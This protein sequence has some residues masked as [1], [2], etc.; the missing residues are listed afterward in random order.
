MK[1]ISSLLFSL[2]IHSLLAAAVITLY[3]FA[4]HKLKSNKKENEKLLCI[5]LK[6]YQPSQMEA[7]RKSK[8]SEKIYKR[9]NTKQKKKQQVE[10]KRKIQK[11]KTKPKKPKIAVKKVKQE[12]KPTEKKRVKTEKK[13][14]DTKTTDQTPNDC[15]KMQKQQKSKQLKETIAPS[16]PHPKPIKKQNLSQQYIAENI[17]S[18]RELIAENLYYPRKARRRGLEGVVKVRFTLT[19]FGKIEEVTV[20]SSP[21]NILSKAAMT[22]L[23]NIQ[24]DIPHPTEDVKITLSLIYKLKKD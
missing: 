13:I 14:K 3:F 15:P 10:K 22:T 23:E 1:K 12:P 16:S 17:N 8:V 6:N 5:N 24:G 11:Q 2:I 7:T 18:I 20:L 9:S 4:Q 19:R 21:A